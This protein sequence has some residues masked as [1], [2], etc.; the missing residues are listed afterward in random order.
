MSFLITKDITQSNKQIFLLDKN[1]HR[2]KY[3]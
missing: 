3:Q 1:L 2:V